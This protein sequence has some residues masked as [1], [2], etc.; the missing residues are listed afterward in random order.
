ML[1][2]TMKESMSTSIQLPGKCKA[3]LETF[4]KSLQLCSM[5]PLTL[6]SATF[7]VQWSDEYQ[8]DALKAKCEQ[9]LMS[10]A[11]KDGPGLQFAVKY[12]LQKRTKQCLDAFKSRIPEHI[13]D[14]HVLTSQECQEHLIDIWPLIVRHAGLPQMSM[15]PAEHMRSMWPFVSNLCIAAPRPPNFKGCR[16]LSQMFPAS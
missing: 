14:M 6:K 4:Y 2:S 9:F 3:E 11:P 16:G 12:G 13:S 10:N 8:V 15:P 7:L 5:E 1:S